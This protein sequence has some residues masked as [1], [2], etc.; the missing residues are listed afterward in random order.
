MIYFF[1]HCYSLVSAEEYHNIGAIIMQ[2]ATHAH[3]PNPKTAIGSHY[4]ASSAIP[5]DSIARISHKIY[6]LLQ[7]AGVIASTTPVDRPRDM[8][9]LCLDT[10]MPLIH[11]GMTDRTIVPMRHRI[12]PSEKRRQQIA[13]YIR[14]SCP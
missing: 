9:Q 8:C 2:I 6:R 12:H 4:A 11:R 7:Y 5:L 1:A 13:D 3:G 10:L 14:K